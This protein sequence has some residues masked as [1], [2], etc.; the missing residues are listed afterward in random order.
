MLAVGL[1]GTKRL[2]RLEKRLFVVQP[3]TV[4][5]EIDEGKLHEAT[6]KL[7][8]FHETGKTPAFGAVESREHLVV[9]RPP[10]RRRVAPEGSQIVRLE[11]RAS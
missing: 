9:R 11:K 7:D 8:L 4:T 6:R 5:D 1:V 2:L 3:L 10:G